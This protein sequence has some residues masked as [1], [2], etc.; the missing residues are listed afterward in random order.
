MAALRVNLEAIG[1]LPVLTLDGDADMG[2]L[3][4]LSDAL[5]AA[6]D[7]HR[8]ERL[9]VDLDALGVLDDLAFGSLLGAAGRA[10]I[11]GGDLVLIASGDRLLRRLAL[12]GVDRALDVHRSAADA[13]R[14]RR[15]PADGQR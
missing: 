13:A 3:P 11:H 2:S 14:P 12:T 15:G 9:A 5:T 10:R 8:G 6:V 4:R 7:A 1:E